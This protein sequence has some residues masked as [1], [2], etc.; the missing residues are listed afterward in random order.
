MNDYV[1][2]GYGALAAILAL[3]VVHLRHRARVLSRALT[4]PAPETERS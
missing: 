2:G 3:Y 1:A 4:P